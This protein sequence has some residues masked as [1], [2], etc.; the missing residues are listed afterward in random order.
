MPARS[1]LL[2]P[3]PRGGREYTKALGL[4]P[5]LITRLFL[6]CNIKKED[7]FYVNASW[8]H[9]FRPETNFRTLPFGFQQRRSM[10][11]PHKIG[12]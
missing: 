8:M 9:G 7:M 4:Y 1:Q 10:G 12:L 3:P 6:H 2:F 11:Q 5:D